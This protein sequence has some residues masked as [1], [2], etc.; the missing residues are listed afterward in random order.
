VDAAQAAWLAA[1]VAAARA[2]AANATWVI[3]GAHRPLYCTNGGGK[4]TDCG[5][6]APLLRSQIEAAFDAAA[7]DL[8]LAAHMHGWERTWPVRAGVP[9]GANFSAPTAP[10]YVVNGAAGNREGNED[11]SGN[12][13]WSVPGAHSGDIGYGVI[14]VVAAPGVPGASSLR[15]DFVRAVD[16]TVLD[17]FTITK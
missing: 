1:D 17:T 10:V 3:A 8:V 14:T 16:G 12:A 7:V 5:T 15:Y 13:A 2:G 9:A 11:P 4:D 6:Y